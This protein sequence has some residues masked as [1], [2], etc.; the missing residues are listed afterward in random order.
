MLTG[1]FFF[2]LSFILDNCDGDVAR[3]KSMQTVFGMWYD[4]LADL[5]VDFALWWGL[6]FG[7]AREGFGGP[8]HE[9]AWLACVGSVLNLGRVVAQR[10]RAQASPQAHPEKRR[11]SSFTGP[12][13]DDGDPS[14]LIW[15]LALTAPPPVF[16]YGGFFY[17]YFVWFF[18]LF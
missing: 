10:R 9:V 15:I 1:A 18:S 12:L 6:A 14:V 17:I 5:A 3:I 4:Y 11:L 13:R 16:L 2:H 8:L 7:A